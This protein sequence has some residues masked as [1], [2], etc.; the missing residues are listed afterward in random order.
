MTA[1]RRLAHPDVTD[2]FV[3]SPA[4]SSREAAKYLGIGLTKLY[5]LVRAGEVAH[6]DLG[7]KFGF[8]RNDLDCWHRLH[9]IPSKDER[10]AVNVPGRPSLVTLPDGLID[11]FT[12]RPLSE[13]VR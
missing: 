11:I 7:G 10:A 3:E 6:V 12:G 8:L 4:L 9:R 1:R 13:F 2:V 5:E